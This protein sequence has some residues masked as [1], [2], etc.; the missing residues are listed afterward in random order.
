MT[1]S[2]GAVVHGYQVGQTVVI[3]T[4][5][6]AGYQGTYVITSVPT[7]TTFTYTNPNLSLVPSTTAEP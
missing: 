1:I 3:A 4:V 7:P 5:V 6:P 2:T